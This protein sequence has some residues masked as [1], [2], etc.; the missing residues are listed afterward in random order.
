MYCRMQAE[1]DSRA[2]LG[3]ADAIFQRLGARTYQ[4]RVAE[5]LLQF[6]AESGGAG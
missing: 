1:A 3:R 5:T 4:A 6:D 2:Y